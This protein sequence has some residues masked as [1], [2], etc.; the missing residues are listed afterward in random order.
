MPEGLLHCPEA[1]C[2]CFGDDEGFFFQEKSMR[3][4]PRNGEGNTP[5]EVVGPCCDSQNHPRARRAV[6]ALIF[7]FSRKSLPTTEG[8]VKFV[9]GF[10]HAHRV[11]S[12]CRPCPA[13][14][15]PLQM[16]SFG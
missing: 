13:I 7:T 6:S 11:R 2:H 16:C 9:V 14:R 5:P 15:Y 4:D 1:F 3:G 8:F 12:T 10:W